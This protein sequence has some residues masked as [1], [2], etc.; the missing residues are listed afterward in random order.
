MISLYFTPPFVW[1][2]QTATAAA[3]ESLESLTKYNKRNLRF[4]V[5]AAIRRIISDLEFHPPSNDGWMGL[6]IS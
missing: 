5:L 3:T 4:L 1:F 6:G 2:F